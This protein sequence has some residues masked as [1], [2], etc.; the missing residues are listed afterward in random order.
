[1]SALKQAYD[2]RVL[3]LTDGEKAGFPANCISVPR[4]DVLFSQTSLDALRPSAVARLQSWGLRRHGGAVDEHE[5]AGGSLRCL[6]AE[7][8]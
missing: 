7:G 1:M 4:H 6:L 3:P 2:G 8:F 5:K